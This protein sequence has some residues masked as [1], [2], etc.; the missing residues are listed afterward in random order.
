MKTLHGHSIR[1]IATG[2]LA[3]MMSSALMGQ[4]TATP[5]PEHAVLKR[6]EGTWN[7]TVKMGDSETPGTATYKLECSGLW[8]VSDFRSEFGGQPFQGRGLDSYDPAKKKYVSVW[9][10][11]MTTRPLLLEGEF[12]K[13]KKTL[14]MTGEGPGMDG[15]PAKYRNTTHIPDDDHLTFTMFLTGADGKETKV[16]TIE[17][18]KKK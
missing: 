3:A 17:Y 18:V 9:V 6:L 10:D 11:S 14:T 1:L 4:P 13:A 2:C 15:K 8:L 7:A 5:G 12:D 16:M